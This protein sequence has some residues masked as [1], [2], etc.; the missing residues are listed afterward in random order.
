M[1]GVETTS[2]AGE[3]VKERRRRSADE[4]GNVKRPMRNEHNGV[5]SVRSAKKENE[6]SGEGSEKERPR[7]NMND[8]NV[9]ETTKYV[10]QTKNTD[11]LPMRETDTTMTTLAA[12]RH[13]VDR[14]TRDGRQLAL[15]DMGLHRPT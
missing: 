8:A 2:H 12:T 10:E 14:I 4:I 6:R 5:R 15:M 11:E 1:S 9:K 7:R 13:L 3:A